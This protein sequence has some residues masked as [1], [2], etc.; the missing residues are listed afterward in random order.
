M[1]M[2]EDVYEL[3]PKDVVK[4]EIAKGKLIMETKMAKKKLSVLMNL[5]K[6]EW[7]EEKIVK[8]VNLKY[9]QMLT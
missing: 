3:D 8:D 1:T 9:L 2:I 5:K 7:V 4:E 6:T